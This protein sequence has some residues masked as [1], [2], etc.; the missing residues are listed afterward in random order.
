MNRQKA[1]VESDYLDPVFLEY[2]MEVYSYEFAEM[3][4]SENLEAKRTGK[5]IW[6]IVPQAGFQEKVLTNPADI[7]VCGGV[8]GPG[9]QP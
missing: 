2:G 5:R 8:R 1:I 6:N 7:I 9:R 4:R 3:M